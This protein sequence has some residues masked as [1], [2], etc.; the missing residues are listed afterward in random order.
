M[1][2]VRV[3]VTF[4]LSYKI[5]VFPGL[6][7]LSLLTWGYFQS[8]RYIILINYQAENANKKIK[9]LFL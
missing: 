6:P 7:E 3:I 8:Q 1:I 4:L 5:N 2:F 9:K